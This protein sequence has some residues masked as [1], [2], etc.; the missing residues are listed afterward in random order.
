MSEVQTD[1]QEL[2]KKLQELFNQF[3][4]KHGMYV[5]KVQTVCNHCS[6]HDVYVE[7]KNLS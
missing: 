5:T 2:N 6:I 3:Y 1:I 7:V 4:D